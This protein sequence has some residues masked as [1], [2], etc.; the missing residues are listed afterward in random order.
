LLFA[1]YACW[2]S[3]A[4]AGCPDANQPEILFHA[5]LSGRFATPACGKPGQASPA[6]YAALAAALAD[7]RAAASARSE[8][9]PLTILGG[10]WAGPD[11]FATT[12]LEQGTAGERAL[13]ALLA[14]GAYDAIALGHDELS[15]EP[16]VLDGLLAVMG[17]AG[18]PIVATNLTCDARRPSCAAIQHE[19]FVRTAG[20]QFS[21]TPQLKLRGGAGVQ[22]ELL[23]AEGGGW[24][25]VLE[26]GATLDPTPIAT[27]GALAVK[28]E[29][30]VD[31]DL[32][33][34]TET[35]Q[36]QLRAT[37]KLS[38]PLVPTLFLT[39]GLD[40]FAAQRQ[41]EG[42]GASYDTTIGPRVHTD[43]AHQPL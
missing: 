19:I 20:A 9:P 12:L 8:P 14:R 35:R 25:A 22:R 26:A 16:A 10:N 21:L 17:K 3:H 41:R 32:I 38:V 23:A 28:L 5:D 31:Y 29:G 34:P 18:L 2:T 4:C 24:H 39:V 37:G 1:G 11:P 27:F 42:W 43:F 30:L 36:H 7:A 15:L 6:D 13:A 33:A 40:V